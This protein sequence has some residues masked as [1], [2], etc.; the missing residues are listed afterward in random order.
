MCYVLTCILQNFIPTTSPPYFSP[1]QCSGFTVLIWFT[2]LYRTQPLHFEVASK[3]FTCT[4]HSSLVQRLASSHNQFRVR[5]LVQWWSV[6]YLTV[7]CFNIVNY[8][9]II[10]VELPGVLCS[11]LKMCDEESNRGD[12]EPNVFQ[13]KKLQQNK[14]KRLIVNGNS[15]KST[16]KSGKKIMICKLG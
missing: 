1:N 7:I 6:A 13:V 14:V 3:N 15:Y 4:L 9:L 12:E 5:T 11:V 2:V 16:G 8:C 10:K